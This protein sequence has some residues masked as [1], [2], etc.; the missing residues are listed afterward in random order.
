[1]IVVIS[2][3][4]SS[5]HCDVLL[6]VQQAPIFFTQPID[7]FYDSF[8]DTKGTTSGLLGPLWDY[9]G[10]TL[11][12]LGDFWDPSGTTLEHSGTN[13]GPIWDHYGTTLGLLWDHSGRSVGPEFLR[14]FVNIIIVVAI[15]LIL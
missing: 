10:T 14:S 8:N 7:S 11:R 6:Y 9:S 2:S 4:G 3:D 15:A 13:L 12:H 5:L 1:M